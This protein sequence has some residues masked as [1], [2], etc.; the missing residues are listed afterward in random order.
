MV[1]IGGTSGTDGH[2]TDVYCQG[3]RVGNTA[4][5][6]SGTLTS[7]ITFI[8]PING[9]YYTTGRGAAFWSELY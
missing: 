8:V 9:Q 2:F 6:N 3:I 4:Y 5:T 7:T 1:S